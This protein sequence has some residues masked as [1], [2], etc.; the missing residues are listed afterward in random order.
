MGW[1]EDA[2][3]EAIGEA[4]ENFSK[5]E[6]KEAFESYWPTEE[7]IEDHPELTKPE[8]ALK[9][10]MD[11]FYDNN[12]D[13]RGEVGVDMVCAMMGHMALKLKELKK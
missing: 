5:E 2:T 8:E 3:K 11:G 4:I 13:S 7:N 9:W 6:L 12:H 10:A 1:I